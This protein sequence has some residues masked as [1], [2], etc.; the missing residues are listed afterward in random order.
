MSEVTEKNSRAKYPVGG[1]GDATG[2]R[3]FKLVSAIFKRARIFLKFLK[4]IKIGYTQLKSNFEQ[5]YDESYN[6]DHS[7]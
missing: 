4:S 6:I 2:S 5:V 7:R 3:A 1:D